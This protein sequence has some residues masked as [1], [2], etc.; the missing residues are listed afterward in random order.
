[1]LEETYDKAEMK[2]KNKKRKRTKKKK[3]RRRRK[4]KD[5]GWHKR[6]RTSFID[7]PRGR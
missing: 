4:K 7:D 2:K 3:K 5:Y 6:F 1:L